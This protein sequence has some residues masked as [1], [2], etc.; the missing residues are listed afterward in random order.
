MYIFSKA[1]TIIY[2][3]E[4]E[5][6]KT[7]KKLL[8]IVLTAAMLLGVICSAGVFGVSAAE[9][10]ESAAYS[11]ETV[12][13]NED[14][15]GEA[16]YSVIGNSESV[17]YNADDIY[18]KT[19][20]MTY[21]PRVGL[22][23]L[24]LYDV[25]PQE[26]IRIKIVKNHSVNEDFDIQSTYFVFDVV[27][28]CDVLVT[29]DA[30]TGSTEVLG[31]GVVPFNVRE[32]VLLGFGN[33]AFSWDYTS[34]DDLL[35][36][37]E[38][39]V[40]EITYDD[41]LVAPDPY[42]QVYFGVNPTKDTRPAVS[43]G[44]GNA[45]NEVVSSGVETDAAILGSR[46]IAFKVEENYSSVKLRLDL[47]NFDPITKTGAKFTVTVIPPEKETVYTMVRKSDFNSGVPK[48]EIRMVYNRSTGLYECS[49]T[50]DDAASNQ[51]FYVLKNHGKDGVYGEYGS[52]E[53]YYY[54]VLKRSNYVI[55]FDP[56]TE[57]VGITGDG[58]LSK[59]K[60]SVKTIVAAGNGSGAY[61]N[62]R[63]WEPANGL[64]LLKETSKGIWEIT[65]KNVSANDLYQFK[66]A[67]NSVNS[68]DNPWNLC[69]GAQSA[70]RCPVNREF[71]AVY[72]GREVL[73]K[74]DEDDSDLT[75]RLDIRNFDFRTKQGAKL[76]ITVTPPEPAVD[77]YGVQVVNTG[78]YPGPDEAPMTYNEETGLYEL[79]AE[80]AEPQTI[81]FYVVKNHS[82]SYGDPGSGNK[83]PYKLEIKET[84]DFTITFDP[85][86]ETVSVYGDGISQAVNPEIYSV[87]AAGNGEDTYL[88]GANWDPSDTSNAMKEVSDGVWEMTMT[89][90][91]AYDYYCVKFAVNSVDEDG[92]PLG[93]PWQYNFGVAEEKQYPA[94]GRAID[95]VYW[96][97]NCV[98]SVP[99]D[100]SAVTLRLDLRDFDF[101]T[102]QGAKL[103]ITVTP[104]AL[105][106]DVNG[107]GVV[108]IL[109]A[110]MIQKFA[111][112]KVVFTDRQRLTADF[113]GDGVCDVLDATAI[114]K[115]LVF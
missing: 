63:Y 81:E 49:G 80:N 17:F 29:F 92:N 35:T 103:S 111:V 114:Q 15:G 39:G 96:G 43:Y 22:Y 37:V 2:S 58:I 106:G 56:R 45:N 55:T 57:R 21:D 105:L 83:Y 100:S 42:C 64:N 20:E 86:T 59:E 104:P 93:D 9:D 1:R 85:S 28:A 107:D 54:D 51:E 60:F 52:G 3:I 94:D 90:I 91:Y 72:G 4:S 46:N 7:M 14:V 98:F 48:N 65:Y 38:S 112:E 25:Q 66:L 84:C 8:S 31:D 115:S 36:E 30:E 34:E 6:M 33:E 67:I 97:E 32:V 109:D 41:I 11:G 23:K 68:T 102:K 74:V 50:Y 108:D 13:E 47:R 24:V 82:A 113:N 62:D 12:S 110:V 69:F 61:L 70:E 18:D 53:A 26:D 78:F 5:R 95:A 10:K 99:Q 16:V 88:N 27:S 19:T 79:K 40:W 76:T 87:I 77:A 89:D 44:F 73:F 75:I 101:K 71:D